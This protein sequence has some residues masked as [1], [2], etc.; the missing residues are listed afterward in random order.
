MLCLSI[1]D[2]QTLRDDATGRLLARVN[3]TQ[4]QEPNEPAATTLLL[5]GQETIQEDVTSL[6]IVVSTDGVV[7]GPITVML[8]LSVPGSISD[9]SLELTP[10]S[11][12]ATFTF[13]ATSAG[14]ATITASSAGL[15]SA[16]LVVEVEAVATNPTSIPNW[17]A[18]FNPAIAWAASAPSAPAGGGGASQKL[19]IQTEWE[20]YAPDA[21][22]KTLDTTKTSYTS[23]AVNG[24]F[25]D[26]TTCRRGLVA[27]PPRFKIMERAADP[28]VGTRMM[29]KP[30]LDPDECGWAAKKRWRSEVVIEGAAMHG[31]WNRETWMIVAVKFSETMLQLTPV[32]GGYFT[33]AQYHDHGGGLG[34]NPPLDLTLVGGSGNAAN[35]AL[36]VAVK[37]FNGLT[38]PTNT[39]AD[40]GSVTMKA[41]QI[42]QS[43]AADTW[44]YIAIRYRTGCGF[45]QPTYGNIYG[46]VA[47]DVMSL[48]VN[49]RPFVE[50]WHVA[51]ETDSLVKKFEYVGYWGSPF[52]V[53][54]SNA[55]QNS[56]GINQRPGY[57]KQGVYAKTAEVACAV[58]TLGLKMWHTTN[59]TGIDA[60]SV[61]ADFRGT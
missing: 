21:G 29:F 40:K 39:L 54:H 5:A 8:A 1:R 46:P 34:G 4:V 50:V 2:V 22:I 20:G 44:H 59:N 52:Y 49:Q 18:W 43:P 48:P 15:T 30:R 41:A 13:V 7:S 37:R 19:S 31:P 6:P 10:S 14:T 32:S 27:G 3:S 17:S 42:V 61:L 25:I 11:P 47:A 38:W 12:S 24:I 58:D 57:W 28:V 16:Q 36:R 55:T 51:G 9:A 53:G 35:S 56:G 45:T 33:F 60:P 26:S 23:T